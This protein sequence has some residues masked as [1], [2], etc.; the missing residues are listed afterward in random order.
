MSKKSSLRRPFEKQPG[1][2]NTVE[3]WTAPTLA[4]LL[5][6]VKAIELEKISVSDMQSL[7]TVF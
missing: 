6:N 1:V 4:H 2:P 3:I 7:K 5:I